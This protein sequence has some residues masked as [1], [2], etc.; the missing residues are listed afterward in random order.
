M[1]RFLLITAIFTLCAAQAH[2]EWY[3]R[4]S[5]NGWGANQ[6]EDVGNN[7]MLARNVVF[8]SDGAFKF[9]RWAEWSENYGTGGRSGSNIGI[10]AG[11]YNIRFYTDTKDWVVAVVKTN[12]G[13]HFRG[14]ANGWAEG[15]LLNE[16]ADT[17]LYQTCQDF[18]GQTS[19]R[20]KIDP[21]GGWAGDEFPDQDPG[22]SARYQPGDDPA[23]PDGQ[24]LH[25][26][27]RA[28]RGGRQCEDLYR[29]VEQ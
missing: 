13:Y 18:N 16:I 6:M 25:G 21:N 26:R 15:T 12:T 20:F 24:H 1:I 29:A 3:L 22:R 9:D 8:Q 23:D 19:P 4:G 2:A 5:H 7:T 10:S 14:T 11:T 28:G 17:S 27:R